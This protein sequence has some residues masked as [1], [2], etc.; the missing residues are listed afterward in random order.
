MRLKEES[1]LNW[2]CGKC[3]LKQC[4]S[5][6]VGIRPSAWIGFSWFSTCIND[7]IGSHGKINL[8]ICDT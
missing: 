8:S 1:F 2:S 6:F 5:K 4:D 7:K 3:V